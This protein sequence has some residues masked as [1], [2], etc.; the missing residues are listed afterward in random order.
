MREKDLQLGFLLFLPLPGTDVMISKKYIRQ[1]NRSKL[2]FL[3]SNYCQLSQKFDY[4]IVFFR[5]TPIISPRI[6]NKSQKG[7]IITSS[8]DR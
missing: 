4:I 6:G 8:P 7:M 2:A 3:Y 5:K 1:K